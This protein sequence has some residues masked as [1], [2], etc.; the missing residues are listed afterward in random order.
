MRVGSKGRYAVIALLDVAQNS[1]GGPVP[2]ADVAQR[3]KISL[4]YLEQLFAMLR[5][6]NVVISS[7]GPGG[8]YRLLRGAGAITIGEVFRAVED[9]ASDR[10]WPRM[11]ETASR[12]WSALDEHIRDF[13]ESVTVADVLAG[14]INGDAAAAAPGMPVGVSA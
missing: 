1:G 12:L 6:G 5:R 4:S 13:L 7:R 11:G 10:D 8:G 14:R 3:Q 2:L 9:P